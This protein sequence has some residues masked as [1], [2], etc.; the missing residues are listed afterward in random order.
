VIEGELPRRKS[1]V[2]P[3]HQVVGV[4]EKL[5]GDTNASQSERS[6]DRLVHQTD[7]TCEYCCAGAENFCD[8]PKSPDI[9]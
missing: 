5:G 8:N 6:R 9:A 1:P 3:G 7:G 2:I 4:V